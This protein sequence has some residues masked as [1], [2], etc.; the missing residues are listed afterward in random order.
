MVLRTFTLFGVVASMVGGACIGIGVFW[1]TTYY[2]NETR[3]ERMLVSIARDIREHYVEEVPDRSL[4]DNA[5]RGMVQ[6][7]DD[8]STFLDVDALLALEEDTSGRFGG[9]GIEVGMV[10]GFVTVLSPL[11][12]TPAARAGI[13]A[14]DRIVEVD[15]ESLKGRT[16][17]ETIDE[18]RG[19][20]G[21]TVHLRVRRV[22]LGE[23]LDFDVT[24]DLIASVTGRMLS[25]THGYVRIAQFDKTTG[26]DLAMLVADLQRDGPLGGL[27]LD[28]RNNPGG[29]LDAA[30]DVADA[31]LSGGLIVST[32]GR[33]PD[34]RQ[35]LHADADDLV[36]GAPLAVLINGRSASASEV[37]AGALQDRDRATVLGSESFGKGS[38]Q[39]V[40]RFDGRAIKLTT[41]RYLTP[42]GRS[43]QSGGIEPDIRLARVEREGRKDYDK[44]LLAA[45][46]DALSDSATATARID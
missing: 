26:D 13:A 12:G 2:S 43:I 33:L 34:S 9:I 27:V 32:E 37:V 6:G 24:R 38:V 3:Q 46:L 8:H 35:D 11:D 10:D 36:G 18:V 39:S 1:S 15:H 20:A 5:I 30:V 25:P 44:R 7:L 21:T 42:S 17:T 16:L 14:G 40:M 4:V 31:F 23:T 29:L 28:L 45:A 19:K 22:A 41:A